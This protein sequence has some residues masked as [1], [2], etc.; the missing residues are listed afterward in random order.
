MER[1]N[2][3]RQREFKIKFYPRESLL[4]REAEGLRFRHISAM[5]V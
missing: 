3:T 1:L 4:Y 2:E 5:F